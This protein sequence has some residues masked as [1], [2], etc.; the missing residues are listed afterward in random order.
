MT[1]FHHGVPRFPRRL[2]LRQGHEADIHHQAI[3]HGIR[4][5]RTLPGHAGNH[6]LRCEGA[7]IDRYGS[8]N[9]WS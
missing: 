9:L 6:L 8:L 2:R 5:L 7:G 4:D 1:A 3:P